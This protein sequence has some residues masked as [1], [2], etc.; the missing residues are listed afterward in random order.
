MPDSDLS[1]L[2]FGVGIVVTLFTGLLVIG[3]LMKQVQKKGFGQYIIYRW[4]VAAAAVGV[5]W[6]RARSGS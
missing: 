6:Y 4:L 5:Y 3:G 1:W 2:S